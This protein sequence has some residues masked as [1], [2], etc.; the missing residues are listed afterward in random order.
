MSAAQKNSFL[1]ASK[2]HMD[3]VTGLPPSPKKEQ[4]TVYQL[5]RYKQ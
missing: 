2:L 4:T 5:P 3:L 1:L